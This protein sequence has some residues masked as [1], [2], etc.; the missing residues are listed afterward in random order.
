MESIVHAKSPDSNTDTTLLIHNPD[1][2]TLTCP[3]TGVVIGIFTKVIIRIKVEEAGH[4]SAQRSKV[5][6]RLVEPQIPGLSV[7]R[8]E[9]GG[10]EPAVVVV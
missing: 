5:V 8:L 6:L 1:K 3:K 9:G 10:D 4:S 2:D 7:D